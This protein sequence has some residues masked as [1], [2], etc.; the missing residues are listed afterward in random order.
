[1]KILSKTTVFLLAFF[2]TTLN[3]YSFESGRLKYSINSDWKFSLQIENKQQAFTFP[4]SLWNLINIPHTWNDKDVMDETPGYFRGTGWY[5]KEI[6]LNEKES[7]KQVFLY[8]EGANQLASVFVNG[9]LAGT[10]AGGYNAF[11]FDITPY[12]NKGRLSNTIIV[13]LNNEHNPDIPPHNADFSY[14]GGIYRDVYLMVTEP[15]HFDV[16]DYASSGV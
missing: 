13:E 15:V 14:L 10:H 8:F 3:L 5:K 2:I 16:L 12:L 11:S 4:D 9:K 7:G 1:M 6:F